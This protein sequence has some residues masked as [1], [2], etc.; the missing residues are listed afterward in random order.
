MSWYDRG[1]DY[2]FLKGIGIRWIKYKQ[3]QIGLFHEELKGKFIW[4]PTTGTLVY[5]SEDGYFRRLKTKGDFLPKGTA[6]TNMTETVYL[7]MINMVER[8][9][10]NPL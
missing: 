10:L 4:Y 3:W 2:T 9:Q 8:Q 1:I 6:D 5:E 7:E